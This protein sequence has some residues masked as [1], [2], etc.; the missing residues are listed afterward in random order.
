M[1]SSARLLPGLTNVLTGLFGIL[2]DRRIN[3]K[4]LMSSQSRFYLPG[5]AFFEIPVYIDVLHGNLCLKQSP[6]TKILCDTDL[7]ILIDATN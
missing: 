3:K 6:T 4:L 7:G 1:L 5:L 2:K